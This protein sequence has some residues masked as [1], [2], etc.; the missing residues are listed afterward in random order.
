MTIPCG[1]IEL[2]HAE[3]S[4][5]SMDMAHIGPNATISEVLDLVKY[6]TPEH[7]G[8]PNDITKYE[9]IVYGQN[10]T[11]KY[12]IRYDYERTKEGF[13]TLSSVTYGT[14]EK[15]NFVNQESPEKE[16]SREG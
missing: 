2:K 4:V 7:N 13:V 5:N 10:N 11:G 1:T 12:Y 8:T 14:P 16:V 3:K 6:Y 9:F 15:E